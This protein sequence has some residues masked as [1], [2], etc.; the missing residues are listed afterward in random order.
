[1]NFA[2]IP[3]DEKET[4]INYDYYSKVVNIYTSRVASI[5]RLMKILGEGKIIYEKKKVCSMEWDIPF[6]ERNTIRKAM[7]LSGLLPKK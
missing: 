3:L 4:I 2:Y 5:K 1:M 7:S 6:S